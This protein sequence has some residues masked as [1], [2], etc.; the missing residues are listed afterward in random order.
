ML[1]KELR[2]EKKWWNSQRISGL[3]I[4]V[5]IKQGTEKKWRDICGQRVKFAISKYQDQRKVR[6]TKSKD[7]TESDFSTVGMEAK[8]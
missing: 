3:E 6:L 5:E 2:G 1:A 4:V 7:L 8:S